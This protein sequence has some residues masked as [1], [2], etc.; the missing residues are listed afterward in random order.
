MLHFEHNNTYVLVKVNAFTYATRNNNI[1]VS[2]IEIKTNNTILKT[3]NHIFNFR[4]Y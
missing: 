1:L 3:I 2:C 4:F